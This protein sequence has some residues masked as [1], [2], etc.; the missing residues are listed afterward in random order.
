MAQLDKT[1][2]DVPESSPN[3]TKFGGY[4]D[5]QMSFIFNNRLRKLRN[6]IGGLSLKN[7]VIFNVLCVHSLNNKE[8][9]NDGVGFFVYA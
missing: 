8:I 4:T 1:V 7:V 2:W 6:P 5:L 3:S 9:R